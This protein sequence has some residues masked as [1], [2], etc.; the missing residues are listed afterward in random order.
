MSQSSALALSSGSALGVL[1]RVPTS[2]LFIRWW[3]NQRPPLSWGQWRRA[4]HLTLVSLV[5]TKYL[6]SGDTLFLPGSLTAGRR[7]PHA[8]K[9]P[10]RHYKV[11]YVYTIPYPA[12]RCVWVCVRM[13]SK[14]SEVGCWLTFHTQCKYSCYP[15]LT[16]PLNHNSWLWLKNPL[17]V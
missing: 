15:S 5:Q 3:M 7:A 6:P 9:H 11:V 17:Q 10:H 16:C 8:H 13:G 2:G 1:L 12:L 4:V 14:N